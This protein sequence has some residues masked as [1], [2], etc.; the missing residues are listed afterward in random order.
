M[1]RR[2]RTTGAVHTAIVAPHHAGDVTSTVELTVQATISMIL[3][4]GPFIRGIFF[5][6][7]TENEPERRR[8]YVG[9]IMATVAVTPG[10]AAVAGKELL[11]LVG[12]DLGAFGFAGG[13]VFALMGFEMLSAVRPR[14]L[15]AGPGR[16]RSEDSIVVPY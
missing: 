11:D 4:I 5:R 9:R 10:L 14:V 12:I 6:V 3:L 2:E 8:E 16:T 7:L 1:G 15:R 13:L